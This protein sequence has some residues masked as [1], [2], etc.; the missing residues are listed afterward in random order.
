MPKKTK[1]EI[2]ELYETI[3]ATEVYNGSNVRFLL[4]IDT[5]HPDYPKDGDRNEK[6]ISTKEQNKL[7]LLIHGGLDSYNKPQ[8][9]AKYNK[10][11]DTYSRDVVFKRP[12]Y[13]NGDGSIKYGRFFAQG[14]SIQSMWKFCRVALSNNRVIGFDLSNSQPNILNQLCKAYIPNKKFNYLDG[15]VRNRDAQRSKIAEYYECS[16]KIAKDLIIRLCFG[17]GINKWRKYWGITKETDLA[18]V[19]GFE[20]DMKDIREI[21]ANKFDKFE[22]V[23]EVYKIRKA[24]GDFDNKVGHCQYKTKIAMYLQNI[25]GNF[26]QYWVKD[27]LPE[28]GVITTT[29]IHDEINV[30]NDENVANNKEDIMCKLEQATK[31]KFGFDIVLKEENYTLND[32]HKKMMKDH[33]KFMKVNDD[34][35]D[36]YIIKKKKF[37]EKCFKIND[38]SEFGYENSRG[39]L[40]IMN[41]TNFTIRWE[42]LT[43]LKKKF[44]NNNFIEVEEPFI[45][46]WF[47]DKD[48]R[49]YD[50]YDFLPPPLDCPDYVYNMWKGFPIIH[51]KAEPLDC[52]EITELIWVVSGKN[53]GCYDYFMNWLAQMVQHPA[54]KTGT[55]MLLKSKQGAGK[56]TIVQ[57]MRRI[58]GEY[59]TETSDP[60]LNIFGTHGNSHIGKILVSIDEVDNSDTCKILGKLKNII[61]SDKCV[62]NEKGLKQVEVNN[63]C[64]FIFTTN[65]PIPINLEQGDRRYCLIES[66]ND[67]C[68]KSDFWNNYYKNVVNNPGKIKAFYNMLMARDISQVDWM[69]FPDTEFKKDIVKVSLH[70]VV[71]WFD[72]YIHKAVNSEFKVGM[73][74]LYDSY[75][76]YCNGHNIK[77]CANVNAFGLIFKNQI[78]LEKCRIAK[79]KSHGTMKLLI[80]RENVFEWLM[81]N[82]FTIYENLSP[83]NDEDSDDEL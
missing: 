56:G 5:E 9:K 82:D 71:F 79:V 39:V 4:N 37:E 81:A 20:A 17:G 70:P 47:Y 16:E 73:S 6:F 57:I 2:R 21:Y 12:C 67:Y 72:Y 66:C 64:R 49:V 7:K 31:E 77:C 11:D 78:D 3:T 83:F 22:K 32:E 19:K 18:F 52:K 58:M 69:K 75:M 50:N 23:E 13:I 34:D 63:M 33:E 29:P 51:N 27:V 65:K 35:E 46:T 25:E 26:I 59:C 44:M 53:Q 10:K 60:Q 55:A 15:Y 62:Y 14:T 76:E 30:L 45:K 68:L 80:N 24:N 28:L 42:E 41:K 48:K 61:T 36:D 74:A 1:Q 43:F 38:T 54:V 40:V 8:S